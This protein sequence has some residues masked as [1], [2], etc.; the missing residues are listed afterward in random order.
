MGGDRTAKTPY[1]LLPVLP[2]PPVL[3]ELLDALKNRSAR[4]LLRI[5]HAELIFASSR[6]CLDTLSVRFV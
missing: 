6:A 1:L 5:H 4:L 2:I 3:P